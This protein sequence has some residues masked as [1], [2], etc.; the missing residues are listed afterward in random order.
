MVLDS[1][2]S[3]NFS[4]AV[5][6]EYGPAVFKSIQTDVND[7]LFAYLGMTNASCDDYST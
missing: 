3:G 4:S 7:A 2:I 6:H 1:F 5:V